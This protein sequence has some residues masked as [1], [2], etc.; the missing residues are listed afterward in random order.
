MGEGRAERLLAIRTSGLR[1]HR[2]D[3]HHHTHDTVLKDTS[4]NDLRKPCQCA[5]SKVFQSPTLNHVNPLRGFLHAPRCPQQH[6]H[7]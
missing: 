5:P 2:N 6:F 1:S 4:P 7:F 3:G